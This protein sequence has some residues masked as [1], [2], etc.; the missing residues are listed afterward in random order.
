MADSGQPTV[1]RSFPKSRPVRTGRSVAVFF[2]HGWRHVSPEAQ[3]RLDRLVAGEPL[4]LAVELTNPATRTAIQ[5]Q[6]RDYHMIGWAPRYLLNDLMVAMARTPGVYS[7]FVV[8]VNPVPAPSKQRVLIELNGHLP[9]G[10]EPMSGR[11]F[12]PLVK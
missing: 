3:Q 12:E 1:S 8:R 4:Y 9:V 11:E 10:Y 5:I 7:A 6:T 2:L